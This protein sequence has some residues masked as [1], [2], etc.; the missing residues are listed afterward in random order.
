MTSYLEHLITGEINAIA[1]GSWGRSELSAFADKVT[2][3]H[4][5]P[6]IRVPAGNTAFLKGHGVGTQSYICLP[7]GSSFAWTFFGPQA[8][9][10]LTFT[11]FG[12][13]IQQQII[14]HFLS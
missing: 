10:F 8:T 4:V 7:S 3:P 2:P 1:H 12:H 14:T 9:L 6:D 5:P 11:L 13:T